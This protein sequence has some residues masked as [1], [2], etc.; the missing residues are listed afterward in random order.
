MAVLFQPDVV[1]PR[2]P[3]G[4]GQWL[5]NHGYEHLR[6][7]T[8]SAKLSTPA[9]IPD[10]DLFYWDGNDNNAIQSW[11]IFHEQIHE[12]LRVPANVTGIDLSAVNLK[13]DEEWFIWLD[14]HA[15]EH[16]ALRSFFGAT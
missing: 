7:A 9:V 5:Q 6:M 14:D 3:I 13:D 15:A 8:L 10:Y 1:L 2:D 12:A 11:L 4:F 16:Q